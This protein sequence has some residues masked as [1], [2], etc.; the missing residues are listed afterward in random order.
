MDC[1]FCLSCVQCISCCFPKVIVRYK[2]LFSQ[3]KMTQKS[4]RAPN[5]LWGQ[6]KPLLK[7]Y[8]RSIPPSAHSCSQGPSLVSILDA[9][10]HDSLLPKKSNLLQAVIVMCGLRKQNLKQGFR[11]ELTCSRA[12]N[13]EPTADGRWSTNSLWHKIPMQMVIFSL[14]WCTAEE[15]CISQCNVSEIVKHGGV[16]IIR[17]LE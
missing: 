16:V 17:R 3:L 13:E 6:L 11:A 7:L 8:H 5:S 4:T 9:N 15:K 14:G 1:L 12:G 10:L 2:I